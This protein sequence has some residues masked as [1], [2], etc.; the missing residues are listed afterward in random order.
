MSAH[1]AAA[2]A[3][4]RVRAVLYDI[5]HPD[6]VLD[7]GE[8]DRALPGKDQ[9]L[10][11]DV[12]ADSPAD[13][14]QAAVPLAA[15]LG[16]Q[17]ADAS[18]LEQDEGGPYL[19]NHD[20]WFLLQAVAVEQRETM[21]F[22]GR[23]LLL[24][25]G[26]NMVLSVHV[27]PIGFLDELRAR[28]QADSRIGTLGAESFSVSL[29]G[30]LVDG[31]LHA[32]TAFEAE[33]DRLEVG[34]L[35]NPRHR[36]CLPDL[37]RLRRAASRLR[38]LLAP[39]RAVFG[40]MA[41]PDFRPDAG[42]QVERQFSALE[43]RFERAMDAVENARD[44][45]VGTFEL[46]STRS[47]ERTNDTMRVLTFVTVMLGTLAVVVGLFGMNFQAAVLETGDAGFWVVV[48]GMLAFALGSLVVARWRRWI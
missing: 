44:L 11:V 1:P 21:R 26:E 18:A 6:R 36:E 41:R 23:P 15:R 47:A 3:A 20:D 22:A 29:L 14:L 10:W 7:A 8:I 43:Q 30:W 9:L 25:C 2:P 5:R 37:A 28:E 17:G 33:V 35:A 39:H 42:E 40:A 27:G 19:R 12:E 16:L 38:R 24:L 46:Y 48:A 34:L 13:A 45:L 32:V 31:Y 4:P